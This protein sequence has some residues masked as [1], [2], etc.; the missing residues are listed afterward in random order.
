MTTS[1]AIKSDNSLIVVADSSALIALVH[2]HD[3]DYIKAICCCSWDRI[4]FKCDR[5]VPKAT[6]IS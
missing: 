5:K 4:L 2:P 1:M 6:W 3:V